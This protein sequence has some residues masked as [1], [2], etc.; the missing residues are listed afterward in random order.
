[1]WFGVSYYYNGVVGRLV[2]FKAS[3]EECMESTVDLMEGKQT[4]SIEAIY[5]IDEKYCTVLL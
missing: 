1:M 3:E 4:A 2:I 5:V